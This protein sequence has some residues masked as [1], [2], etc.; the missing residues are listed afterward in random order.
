MNEAILRD[1]LMNY[2]E[3]VEREIYQRKKRAKYTAILGGVIGVI[4]IGSLFVI[5]VI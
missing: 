1:N 4:F 3:S 2:E 5:A